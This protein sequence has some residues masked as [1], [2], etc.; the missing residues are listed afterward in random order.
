MKKNKGGRPTKITSKVR[1]ILRDA[2]LRG[3]TDAEACL[4]ANI[5]PMT[6]QRYQT[7]YPKFSVL[8]TLWKDNI[9]YKARANVTKS[10]EG[11]NVTDSKWYLARKAKGEFAQR[12][13][14]TGEDG[15]DL[16]VVILPIKEIGDND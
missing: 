9:K 10:V 7:K 11:G 2:F 1:T 12:Q 16:G 8:K 4:V 5:N 6:L 15:K 14:I 13:E 3:A